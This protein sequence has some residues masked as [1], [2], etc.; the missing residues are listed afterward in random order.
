MRYF[1]TIICI[2]LSGTVCSQTT[3]LTSDKTSYYYWNGYDW[4]YRYERYTTIRFEITDSHVEW[5]SSGQTLMHARIHCLEPDA[6]SVL[7]WC[8]IPV[9]I[10]SFLDFAEIITLSTDNGMMSLSL[11]NHQLSVKRIFNI[12]DFHVD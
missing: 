11:V 1:I 7:L 10:D 9:L 2:L 5:S 12:V 4:E 3:V 8:G 6:D